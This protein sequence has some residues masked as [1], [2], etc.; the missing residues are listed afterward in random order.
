MHESHLFA[1]CLVSLLL[2]FIA[3][4][5]FFFKIKRSAT[6]LTQVLKVMAVVSLCLQGVELVGVRRVALYQAVLGWGILALSTTLFF[7]TWYQQRRRK[8]SEVFS[9]KA[10]GRLS[11]EGNY[12]WIRH[13]FYV[14]YIL[15]YVAGAVYSG[16]TVLAA[17]T[18]IMMVLYTAA[19]RREERSIRSTRLGAAYRSYAKRVGGFFPKW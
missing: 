1:A 14:S 11:T 13:P 12:R 4:A 3:A 8:F 19:A 6:A 15:A 16:S 9:G 17:Q 10:P 7:S 2:S 18:A 5:L